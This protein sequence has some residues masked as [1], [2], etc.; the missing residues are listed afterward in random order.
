MSKRAAVTRKIEL[1]ETHNIAL[2][3]DR[4]S[5][6]PYD[7]DKWRRALYHAVCMCECAGDTVRKS[8]REALELP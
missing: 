5:Q 6:G 3:L 7:R 2:S 8:I 1:V 4:L